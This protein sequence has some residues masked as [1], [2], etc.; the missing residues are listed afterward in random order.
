MKE[1]LVIALI[2]ICIA[3]C[4]DKCKSTDK[5]PVIVPTNTKTENSPYLYPHSG[6][7]SIPTNGLGYSD[8]EED[9]D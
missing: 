6:G 4:T 3:T 9:N 1:F 7:F 8:D 5:Q 2:I